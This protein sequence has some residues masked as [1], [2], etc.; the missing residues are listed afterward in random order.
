MSVHVGTTR[1][2]KSVQQPLPQNHE[3]RGFRSRK[4]GRRVER[5]VFLTVLK[6]VVTRLDNLKVTAEAHNGQNE[7]QACAA[8]LKRARDAVAAAITRLGRGKPDCRP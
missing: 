8:D 6:A 1:W 5:E 4:R 7:I 3:L 2:C